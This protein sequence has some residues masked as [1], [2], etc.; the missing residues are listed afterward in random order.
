MT[1][2]IFLTAAATLAATT[3]IAIAPV[4]AAGFGGNGLINQRLDNQA[5]R[6]QQGVRSGAL[7]RG[8]TFKLKQQ[9]RRIR[10][11]VRR[12]RA[13]D[14]RIDQF[15]RQQIQNAINNASRN[16]RN[17]KHNNRAQFS[18]GPG[19]GKYSG[20]GYGNKRGAKV[21]KKDNR[22]GG[23]TVSISKYF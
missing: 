13:D 18:K 9:Q 19:Y 22:R 20:K 7:T 12:S 16:I 23:L 10:T 1:A 4:S 15:E 14:G 8:E 17:K 6:I 2:K 5:N 11:L 3:L 21:L